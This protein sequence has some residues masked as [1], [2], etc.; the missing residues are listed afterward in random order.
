MKTIRSDPYRR[1]RHPLEY[2]IWLVPVLLLLLLCLAWWKGGE[3][4]V[5]QI[6]VPVPSE[7]LAG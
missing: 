7:K 6:E 3:K 5:T 2:I 4:P 1:R